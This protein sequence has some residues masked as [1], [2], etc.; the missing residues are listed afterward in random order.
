MHV[1]LDHNATTPVHPEVLE[2]ML[3]FLKDHFGNASS[4]HWAGRE[5]KKY[6][7]EAR[8][9]VAALLQADPPEIFFTSGGTESDNMAIKGVAFSLRD[10]GRHIITTPVEHH[11]VLHTCQ[12]LEKNGY[13]VTYLPVDGDGRIDLD[14]LRRSI[15][16]DTI[17]ITI[18]SANNE[19]GT[20]FP[21]KEIGGIARERGVLF[22]TDAVQAVGKVP[23]RLKEL[24]AD[25]LSLSGHKLY[26]PKGIGAQYVR[27]GIRFTPLIHGGAQEG[28]RR[29]GTES[30][31]NIVGLGKACE[32]ARRDF[33]PRVSHLQSL[34]DRL[35]QGILAKIPQVKLNGH[36]TQ[37]LPNTLN[38]S[39]LYIEGESLLLNLDLE[40]VAV[41]SGS[42]CTSGSLDPSHVL[43]AMGVP[44]EIAQSAIRFSLGWKNTL[45]E[46][47]YVLEVLPKIV[48]R[49][50]DMSPLYQRK[51]AKKPKQLPA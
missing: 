34:R 18:M 5:V 20:L 22:H 11:A 15:R 44:P 38:M 50:R 31:P 21:V 39:F 9:K 47:D 2:A 12:F 33:A 36:P 4:I 26:A 25:I 48:E 35:Q 37:R 41:S 7:D 51:I 16:E 28:Y 10:K 32:L 30:I 43:L 40:G 1:Y 13:E 23:I 45:E 29:A 8:E 17:L 19:T 46:V 6:L 27:A 3:P 24:P 42:A 49:L 14:A